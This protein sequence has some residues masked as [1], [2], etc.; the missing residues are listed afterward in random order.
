MSTIEQSI[1]D[2]LKDDHELA[3]DEFNSR[4]PFVLGRIIQMCAR[5]KDHG[6]TRFSIKYAFEVLRR[7]VPLDGNVVA[8]NNNWTA[9]V[10]RVI[11]DERPDLAHMIKTR[12]RHI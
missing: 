6:E 11:A 9:V 7:E 10:G 5:A 3:W 4:H 12:R 1:F 8:L 2:S